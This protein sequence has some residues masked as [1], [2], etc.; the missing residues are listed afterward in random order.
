MDWHG[1]KIKFH[2]TGE[3][4]PYVHSADARE[5]EAASTKRDLVLQAG[6]FGMATW[7]SLKILLQ[8][9]STPGFVTMSILIDPD[10]SKF[11]SELMRDLAEINGF[12]IGRYRNGFMQLVNGSRYY[13]TDPRNMRCVTRGQSLNKLH[14][15]EAS[16][17]ED[18]VF[19]A[20]LPCT[21]PSGEILIQSHEPGDG[22]FAR[23]WENADRFSFTR[24]LVT[25]EVR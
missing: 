19:Q 4:I 7:A 25:M 8:M 13:T 15:Q 6:M 3:I 17:M 24:H 9:A 18:E 21:Y 5:F 20:A 12:E 16:F 10:V 11:Y 1:L 23:L 2:P 14:I 22:F